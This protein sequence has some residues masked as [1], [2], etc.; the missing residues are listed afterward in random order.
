MDNFQFDTD[1]EEHYEVLFAWHMCTFMAEEM[2]V[3]PLKKQ[4][5][6]FAELSFTLHSYL[7]QKTFCK[8]N[9]IK[10]SGN[11]LYVKKKPCQRNY[12]VYL[13]M[14]NDIEHREI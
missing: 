2:I 3:C 11:M 8:N 4:R 7:L 6:K 1:L 12:I 10:C 9:V 14:I 13:D 5:D